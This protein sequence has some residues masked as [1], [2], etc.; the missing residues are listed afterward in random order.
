MKTQQCRHTQDEWHR[1][2]G[3]D[4]KSIVDRID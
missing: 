1:P 2:K 3:D 4:H